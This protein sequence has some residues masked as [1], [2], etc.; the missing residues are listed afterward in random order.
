MLGL[1]RASWSLCA[2]TA[3]RHLSLYVARKQTLEIAARNHEQTIPLSPASF[4]IQQDKSKKAEIC[5]VP[6]AKISL[7]L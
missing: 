1:Y 3:V 4:C 2:R 6:E 7:S 5:S